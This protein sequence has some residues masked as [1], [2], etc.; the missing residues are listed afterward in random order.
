LDPLF[1]Q[2]NTANVSQINAVF[3][4]GAALL[5]G[6][7]EPIAATGARQIQLSLDFEF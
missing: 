3:G 7:R 1:N 4:S 5:P 6:F 2:F